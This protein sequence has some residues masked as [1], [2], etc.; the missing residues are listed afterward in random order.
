MN[1]TA[2]NKPEEAYMWVAGEIGPVVLALMSTVIM[3]TSIAT[4]SGIIQAMS[5]SISR[6]VATVINKDISEKTAMKIARI[7]VFII[8]AICAVLATVDVGALINIALLSYQGIIMIF[9][10]V[11]LGLYWKRANKEGALAGMIIGTIVSMTLTVTEPA[12]IANL[13]WSAGVYGLITTTVIMLIAGYA[14][15]VE[16]HVEDLWNDIETARS[17]KKS[18][19]LNA[20]DPAL[21][22]TNLKNE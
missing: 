5:T 19:P 7:S 15:P 20:I 10:V 14:K 17:N 3:A 21:A 4:V 6:D 1:D 16:A 11:I 9:P 8:G 18:V 13:G 2:R 12:L 22:N